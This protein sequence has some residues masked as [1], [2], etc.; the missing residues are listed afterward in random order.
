MGEVPVRMEL[1]LHSSGQTELVPV[2]WCWAGGWILPCSAEAAVL[3]LSR[4]GLAVPVGQGGPPQ[5]RHPGAH[6][7]V[8]RSPPRPTV[9]VG[10][11]CEL[12]TGRQ[13]RCPWR[14][15]FCTEDLA[16]QSLNLFAGVAPPAPR[17]APEPPCLTGRQPAQG[18]GAP[19]LPA[20]RA[21]SGQCMWPGRAPCCSQAGALLT[22]WLLL[23][24][25]APSCQG[26]AREG[27][28]LGAARGCRGL[29]L[30]ERLALGAGVAFASYGVRRCPA[31]LLHEPACS[32]PAQHRHGEENL[33]FPRPPP[34]LAVS[35]CVCL[36]LQ[37]H[38]GPFLP[39]ERGKV[40][41]GIALFRGR[42]LVTHLGWALISA[43]SSVEGLELPGAPPGSLP[44]LGDTFPV[45][46][47]LIRTSPLA[48]GLCF[49]ETSVRLLL[50]RG[51]GWGWGWERSCPRAG[52]SR[53][54]RG[55]CQVQPGLQRS[56]ETKVRGH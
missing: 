21:G 11:L 41:E 20:D 52:G 43:I 39:P 19:A 5:Q 24:P 9:V 33:P 13:S 28:S 40:A 47:A 49:E 17:F 2:G 26:E 42:V 15:Q 29:G 12:C 4:A 16:A 50:C 1:V 8:G 3:A 34:G 6:P 30:G 46:S 31:R 55:W 25:A 54:D 22:R 38:R 23:H 35:L 27:S 7:P 18:N 36:S 14:R 53:G 51:R 32:L 56:C 10:T 48:D 45:N 37:K 44:S